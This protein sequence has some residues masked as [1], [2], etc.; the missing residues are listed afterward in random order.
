MKP[1]QSTVLVKIETVQE[2]SGGIEKPNTDNLTGVVIST[3]EGNPNTGYNMIC[4]P[5]DR[6][7]W[8]RNRGERII[9]NGEKHMLLNEEKG[10]IAAIL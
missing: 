10:E 6:I 3:G 1:I 2:T 5:G 4:K 7:R 8:F 9:Y